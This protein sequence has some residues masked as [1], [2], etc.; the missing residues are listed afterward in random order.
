M[1]REHT[2]KWAGLRT[3][4]LVA[5]GAAFFV[6][7]FWVTVAGDIAVGI[8]NHLLTVGTTG[9]IVGILFGVRYLEKGRL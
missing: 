6:S 7:L 5:L 1:E 3:H 2:G 8:Q 4:M 9:L